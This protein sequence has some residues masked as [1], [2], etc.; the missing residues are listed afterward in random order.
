[1]Y[2]GT[3]GQPPANGRYLGTGRPL[4]INHRFRAMRIL[5]LRIAHQTRTAGA[6]AD[7]VSVNLGSDYAPGTQ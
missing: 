6:E 5:S 1:M 3:Y 4:Q 7:G 2:C